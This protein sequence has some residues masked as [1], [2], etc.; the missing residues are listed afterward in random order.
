MALVFSVVGSTALAAILLT[1]M[2]VNFTDIV[3]RDDHRNDE[4]PFMEAPVEQAVDGTQIATA[5]YAFQV[6]HLETC[7]GEDSHAVVTD[8]D[9]VLCFN[10]TGQAFEL[11]EMRLLP[12]RLPPSFP[13]G[14]TIAARKGVRHAA[15]FKH[16]DGHIQI[17]ISF[18]VKQP[19]Q[20]CYQPVIAMVTW[21]KQ[22]SQPYKIN[23]WEESAPYPVC[24]KAGES[25]SIKD[26]SGALAFGPSGD[27]WVAYGSFGRDQ[28]SKEKHGYIFQRK[29][30]Q[31]NWTQIATGLRNPMGISISEN[32]TGWVI[33]NG[34]R[35]GD[36]LNRILRKSDFGWPNTSLGTD[37]GAFDRDGQIALGRHHLGQKP[38]FAWVPSIAPSDLIS[39]SAP[40]LSHWQGDLLISALRGGGL[41]RVRT[42][43]SRALYVEHI[44]LGHRVR[45]VAVRNNGDIFAMLDGH[46]GT[47]WLQR[48]EKQKSSKTEAVSICSECHFA[49]PNSA[50]PSLESFWSQK[51]A[52]DHGYN[53]SPALKQLS[54]NWTPS[55]LRSYLRNP[56]GM[57]PGTTKPNLNLATDE[58][59]DIMRALT[60]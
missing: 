25:Q 40:G 7:G 23:D 49:G 13:Q 9:T 48:I 3:S 6:Q 17:A 30:G 44:P 26:S 27:L 24:V 32:G 33:D 36:E 53:Y 42:E 60:Q 46:S 18:F 55:K 21:E 56:Q 43:E 22:A 12:T 35:G 34:P 59:N 38:V 1:E 14:D 5:F 16:D 54:G 10:R 47:L 29:P 37:Y 4:P 19:Q 57:V 15:M 2:G 11:P 31:R 20:A 58:L 50:G 51:I 39:I 8:G 52:S 41:Y 28:P 45:D